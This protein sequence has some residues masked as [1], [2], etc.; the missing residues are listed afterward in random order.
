MGIPTLEAIEMTKI[1]VVG[2]QFDL[3]A[4][5]VQHGVPFPN[6]DPKSW[7]RHNKFSVKVCQAK[8]CKSFA[9]YGSHAD[10]EKGKTVLGAEDLK[11]AFQSFL[12]DAIYG[13]MSF[14]DFCA[15]TGYDEDSRRA[16][17]IWGA[18]K[19]AYGQVI[20]LGLSESELYDA[21]NELN[22]VD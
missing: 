9:Y 12:S 21:V 1:R 17:K 22:E 10:R 8:K 2:K 19:K 4:R 16:E 20:E 6:E 13:T 11:D 14:E 5:M 15:E 3:S 7:T 18:T